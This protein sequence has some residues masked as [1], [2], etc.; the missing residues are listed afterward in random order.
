MT[1]AAQSVCHANGCS[2]T[3]WEY[4]LMSVQRHYNLILNMLVGD[5]PEAAMFHNDK[6]PNS[7]THCTRE[8]ILAT[9]LC[10]ANLLT[11]KMLSCLTPHFRGYEKLGNAT[12]FMIL[13]GARCRG[14]TLT[15]CKFHDSNGNGFGDIWWTD[16][17][18]FIA[19]L[20]LTH[21]CSQSIQGKQDSLLQRIDSL[22]RQR[23]SLREETGELV[24]ERER[25]EEQLGRAEGERAR[26]KEQLLEEQ[27]SCT[28]GNN[29][30]PSCLTV[31]GSMPEA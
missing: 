28:N 23:E 24:E 31:H 7:G 16:R 22:D 6:A 27:V 13:E 14:N 1:M 30:G 18:I 2:T 17:L 15:T 9:A 12:F 11:I 8:K 20:P 10:E 3:C 25:L 4:R 29:V 19:K 26:M 21:F 5:D